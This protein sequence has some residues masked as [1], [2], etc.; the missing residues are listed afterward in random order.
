MSKR[1]KNVFPYPCNHWSIDKEQYCWCHSTWTNDTH[2][3]VWRMMQQHLHVHKYLWDFISILWPLWEGVIPNMLAVMMR[4]TTSRR[5]WL[6]E[7][8][9]KSL[10]R[11]L[12]LLT[13]GSPWI[14][15]RIFRATPRSLQ[16]LGIDFDKMSIMPLS[17]T[18]SK[19]E[20]SRLESPHILLYRQWI[21]QLGNELMSKA[22]E[23]FGL[24]SL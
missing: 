7:I 2:I 15:P 24:I 4:M 14:F 13:T 20:S 22:K 11:S 21:A 3:Y 18:E 16:A 9:K 17:M 23:S 12:D 5:T 6:V 10:I 19:G 8:V 1:T